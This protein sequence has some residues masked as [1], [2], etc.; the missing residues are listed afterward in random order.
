MTAVEPVAAPPRPP[1]PPS[2]GVDGWHSEPLD[3]VLASLRTSHAGLSGREAAERLAEYG[4]NKLTPPKP[5]SVFA[6]LRAQLTGI[7]VGLLIIAAALALAMG[8]RLESAAI[9]AVLVINTAI[10]FLTEWRARRAMEALSQLDVSRA[11]VVR[12]GRLQLI[13]AEALVPGD[14]IEVN[15]GHGVP[16]DARLIAT[17]DL[18]VTEA[19]LT[20]ESMPVSKTAHALLE[21][22]T[23]LAER[24]NTI[25][26]GTTV[27]AG[28][29]RA[30]VTGTGPRTEV[31]RIGTLVSSVEPEPTPLERRLDALGRRLVWMALGVA[32]VVAALG[33]AQGA[34]LGLVIETGLAL[35]VAAVP[36]AL[37]AVAT[38]ALAVGMRRM[39]RRHALV[40]R[41]PVVE[42]LGSTTVVCTDKTRTLTSGEMTVV[43]V[44]AGGR[45]SDPLELVDHALDADAANVV[46][47]AALASRAQAAEASG[48]LRDPVDAAV[49]EADSRIELDAGATF[50]PGSPAGLVPFSSDRKFMAVFYSHGAV[51]STCAKGGPGAILDRSALVAGAGGTTALLTD[52]ERDR[53]MVINAGFANDGLRVLA[54][55]SGIA[56]GTTE[57]DV[58]DLTFRGFIGLAD[59]PAPGVRETIATLRDAGLRTVMLTGDQRLTAEA[60]GRSLGV[61]GAG[62]ACVDG[63]ELDGIEPSRRDELIGRS[64]AFSRVTPQHKLVIVS[65]LQARGEI[66]AM[67]GDGINDAAAL[68]RADVGVAMG[69]RGT[70]V[71]KEAAAIVLQNDRFE[72][73]AAAVEEGRVIFDNIRKFVFYLFSCNVAEV[74]VLLIAGTLGLPLPLTPLQLLWLNMVTD[75]FPALALALEPG[76][77]DVMRRPPRDPGDAVLS[78]AFIT[79]V[80]AF[81][82]LITLSTLA[83]FAWGL[84]YSPGSASTMAFMTLALAQILH[85]GNARSGGPVLRF[86]RAV[87]NPYALLGAG[88]S[89]GLQMLTAFLPPLAALLHVAAMSTREWIVVIALAALPAIIGQL[90][91]VVRS[92]RGSV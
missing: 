28:I 19:A 50:T 62:E 5:T 30:I 73:I 21:R 70:D 58:R 39:A 78:R 64:S 9:A 29:G 26:K 13:A 22:D 54:V 37:P 23:P 61:L 66:V 65:S 15:A 12:D 52:E 11:S 63:R 88:V 10:G 75:T 72:T 68:K 53:L 36:E 20:G 56:H 74:L 27:A 80:L 79:T 1:E 24:V 81:G 6:I 31:G 46:R 25:F 76:D 32:A 4:P 71:A 7:V 14:L 8:D 69:V 84:A 59:P 34:P 35:A 48:A 67:L 18:R 60:I 82:M 92:A 91:K 45:A 43:R 49:L 89:I 16:A 51:L 47:A 90:S 42:A 85:L 57:N 55:A 17:T 3:A 83:S 86:E 44:W 87:S 33:A 41:L 2:G 38:I 77:P 40:R